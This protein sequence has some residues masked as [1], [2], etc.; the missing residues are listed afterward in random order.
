MDLTSLDASLSVLS[1]YDATSSVSTGSLA[2]AV[3]VSMLDMN[4]ELMETMN[5]QLM[6]SMEHSVTPHLGSNI[7]TY[8]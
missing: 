6:Q 1:G 8:V 2:Y 3:G 4:M 5:Q 7:D